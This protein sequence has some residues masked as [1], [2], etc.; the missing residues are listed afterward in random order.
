MWS[1]AGRDKNQ[2][3]ANLDAIR[4]ALIVLMTDDQEFI[5]SIELSTSAVKMVRMRKGRVENRKSVP[6]QRRMAWGSASDR[7]GRPLR[8]GR[9]GYQVRA[10]GGRPGK[11]PDLAGRNLPSGGG[12]RWR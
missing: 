3:M 2:V 10:S 8:G 5:D 7:E 11:A 6:R 9:P 4:E 12:R 1:L